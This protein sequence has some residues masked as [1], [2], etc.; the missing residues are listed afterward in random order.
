[1]LVGIV[2]VVAVVVAFEVVV[3]IVDVAL[4]A[5]TRRKK[6]FLDFRVVS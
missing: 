3:G 5:L 2:I 1:M 6:A 4:E